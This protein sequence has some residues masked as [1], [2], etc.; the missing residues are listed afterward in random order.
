MILPPLVFPGYINTPQ[1]LTTLKCNHFWAMI[2]INYLD[3][4]EMAMNRIFSIA[5]LNMLCLLITL[6]TNKWAFDQ[7]LF[8][9]NREF[10]LKG[11]LGTVD[12]L[13]EIPCFVDE[14]VFSNKMS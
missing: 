7:P 6:A 9:Q 11:R 10:L 14:I 12:L 8:I 3:F 2:L 5:S 1:A 4:I 13:F